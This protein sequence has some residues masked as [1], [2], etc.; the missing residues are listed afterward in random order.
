MNE[1]DSGDA[2]DKD[3]RDASIMNGMILTFR[4]NLALPQYRINQSRA[5]RVFKP[6]N[7]RCGSMLSTLKPNRPVL[8]F[9]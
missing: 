9:T 8:F 2:G 4:R 7:K 5:E 3:Y 1:G 6:E